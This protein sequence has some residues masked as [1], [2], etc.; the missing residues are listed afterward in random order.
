MTFVYLVPDMKT[1]WLRASRPVFQW[2]AKFTERDD[3][4]IIERRLVDRVISHLSRQVNDCLNPLSR[5]S[6][7]IDE[8]GRRRKKRV[9]EWQL[10]L[11]LINHYF[12]FLC[13]SSVAFLSRSFRVVHLLFQCHE[14]SVS[15][16]DDNDV[17]VVHRSSHDGHDL[18][19]RSVDRSW[20]AGH[21]RR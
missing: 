16:A 9:R 11:H 6:S 21:P 5:C 3:E 7:M 8:R 12:Q 4:L 1:S 17:S 2:H 19:H 14:S 18:P 13:S 20:F 15:S 10:K